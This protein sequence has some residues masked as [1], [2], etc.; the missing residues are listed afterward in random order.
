MAIWVKAGKRNR[1]PAIFTAILCAQRMKN[2]YVQAKEKAKRRVP[3]GEESPEAYAMDRVLDAESAAAYECVHYFDRQGRRG[4]DA[5]KENLAKLKARLQRKRLI[6]PLKRRGGEK[7]LPLP[8][9]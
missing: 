8:W 6:D 1:L 2:A 3:S 7:R 9:K 4:I 5:T